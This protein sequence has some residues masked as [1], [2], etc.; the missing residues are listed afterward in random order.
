M[1]KYYKWH[2]DV[3]DAVRGFVRKA[4]GRVEL[5]RYKQ[6]P[7][8]VVAMLSRLD[9]IAYEG[10]YGKVK[11]R[12]TIATDR[13]RGSAESKWGAD[14]ALTTILEQNGRQSRKAILV[15]SKLGQINRLS[16]KEK[17]RLLDQIS[18]MK[19][20]TSAPKVMEI[21]KKHGKLPVIYSG[22]KI[23]SGE[24]YSGFEFDGYIIR[25]VLTCI[26]G[27]IRPEFVSAVQ[28]SSLSRLQVIARSG[29]ELNPLDEP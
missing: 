26:D 11:F 21:S 24:K 25:Y 10:K 7:T 27:D 4:L 13:A 6:E 18:K 15:Q 2:P 20:A 1:R 14:F 23:F 16:R 19:T 8:L 9:G 5:N 3:R 29:K 17:D 22:N 12:P 28:D